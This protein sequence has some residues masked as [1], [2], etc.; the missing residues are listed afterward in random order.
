MFLKAQQSRSAAPQGTLQLNE[1]GVP[2]TNFS[3]ASHKLTPPNPRSR[4]RKEALGGSGGLAIHSS[5]VRR[6]SLPWMS[7]FIEAQ[8]LRSQPQPRNPHAQH[9]TAPLICDGAASI[10]RTLQA[11]RSESSS[12]IRWRLTCRQWLPS[13]SF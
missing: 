7:R 12:V 4:N 5:Y 11:S 3:T 2:P 10:T 13:Q 8:E 9:T 6:L 1:S